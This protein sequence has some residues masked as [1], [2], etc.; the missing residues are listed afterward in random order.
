LDPVAV[1]LLV[2][3]EVEEENGRRRPA[4]V[5]RE[6]GGEDAGMGGCSLI[7]EGY[8]MPLPR[9]SNI[10]GRILARCL[11]IVFVKRGV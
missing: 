11:V 5:G 3:V 4:A 2:F 6:A 1:L 7:V 8:K 9:W 10:W